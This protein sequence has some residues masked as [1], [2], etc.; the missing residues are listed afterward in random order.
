MTVNV[1]VPLTATAGTRNKITFTVRGV[2][3]VQ[4]AVYFTVTGNTP[5]QDSWAPTLS[6]NY[7]SRCEWK[8][9]PGVCSQHVWSVEVTAQDWDTGILRLQSQPKGL[10]LLQ[11]FTAGTRD[12]VIATYSA[13]CCQ[14]RVT[15][16]AYDAG[17]N[18]KTVT[19][20]VTDIWLSDAAIAAIVVGV[21]LFIVLVILIIIWCV[22]CIRR[23]KQSGELP[24]YR[25]RAR[26]RQ[27]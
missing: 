17:N 20:D 14:P 7:G 4:Q 3:D 22:W 2:T 15:I 10:L 16:T 13:S 9:N 18:L 1:F 21:I 6:W 5:V 23:R 8:S 25:S 24:V 19:L 12:P 27:E 26:S 11:P